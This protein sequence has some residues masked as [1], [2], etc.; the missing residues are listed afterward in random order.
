MRSTNIPILDIIVYFDSDF[1]NDEDDRK[2]YTSYVF[3]INDD[4]ISW[5][6]HKQFT[7]TFSIMEVEYM[8]LSDAVREALTRR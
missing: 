2:Y 3:L 1:A 6:I 7:V 4:A 5:F 8:A